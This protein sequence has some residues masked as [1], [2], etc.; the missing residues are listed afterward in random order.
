MSIQSKLTIVD[1]NAS[2]PTTIA[3]YVEKQME[4]L[5]S[6]CLDADLTDIMMR[7]YSSLGRELKKSHI[8]TA[9]NKTFSLLDCC[10]IFLLIKF[11]MQ[12]SKQFLASLML[13]IKYAD[14][15]EKSSIV[16]GLFFIDEAG[17][18]TD[19]IIDLCRTNS[20]DLLAAIGIGNPY[21]SIFFPQNNFNQL[22][23]KLLFCQLDIRFVIGLFERKN[24]ELSRMASDYKQERINANRTIPLNIELVI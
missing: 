15:E 6:D 17:D 18:L 1:I 22:V 14:D 9:I 2:V 12:F 4:S 10:R 5:K 11:K 7:I 13:L 8:D 3:D 21:P 20:V 16:K 23:L 24:L 19:V